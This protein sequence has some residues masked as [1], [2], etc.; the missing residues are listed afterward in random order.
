M[1]RKINLTILSP[2]K[3]R[4]LTAE[5]NDILTVSQIIEAPV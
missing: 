4:E 2:N 3:S 5:V 1:F